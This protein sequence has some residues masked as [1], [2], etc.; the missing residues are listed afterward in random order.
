MT[1]LYTSHDRSFGPG[2]YYGGHSAL[3]VPIIPKSVGESLHGGPST[4]GVKRKRAK[5]ETYSEELAKE[6][7]GSGIESETGYKP[8]LLRRETVRQM[9]A[10]TPGGVSFWEKESEEGQ[11]EESENNSA[12][13]DEKEKEASERDSTAIKGPAMATDDISGQEKKKNDVENTGK[14]MEANEYTGEGEGF[15]DVEKNFCFTIE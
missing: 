12:T 4:S 13:I 14:N 6:L 7:S 8:K 2:G 3:M 9:L 1:A 11:E 10:Q 15:S 5:N